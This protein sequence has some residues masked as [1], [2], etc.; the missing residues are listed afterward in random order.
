MKKLIL[1]AALV[2]AG[3]FKVSA[4]DVDLFSYDKSA[5]QTALSELNVLES[6]VIEHPALAIV[7]TSENGT[8]MVNGIKLYSNPFDN[9]G[10][11]PLGIPAFLWGCVLDWVGILV[12]YLV[13]NNDHEQVRKAIWG[14][15]ANAVFWVAW[16]FIF[17]AAWFGV[18]KSVTP[19]YTYY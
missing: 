10:G 9:G 1:I 18:T 15:A 17:Y 7:Q 6:Y 19:V 14:C 3:F 12:V 16:Y 8:M 11:L 4:N 13:T 5:V 2:V